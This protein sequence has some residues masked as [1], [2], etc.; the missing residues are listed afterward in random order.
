MRKLLG[1]LISF[2]IP[3]LGVYI[4]F[5]LQEQF[6][7]SLALTLLGFLPGV[8]HAVYVTGRS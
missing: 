1:I 8:A 7:V 4:R 3:P 5:G 6:W 2:F